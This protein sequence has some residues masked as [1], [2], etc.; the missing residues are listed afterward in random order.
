MT[1]KSDQ[2]LA[3]LE[4][5]AALDHLSTLKPADLSKQHL[6]RLEDEL[7]IEALSNVGTTMQFAKI[8]PDDPE[9]PEAWK[10]LDKTTLDEKMR[11]AK[12]AWKG[13]GEVP[14][15]LKANLQVLEGIL[16]NRSRRTEERKTL[17]V[18]SIHLPQPTGSYPQLDISDDND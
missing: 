13:S 3:K 14:F 5:Q 16:K 7:L 8:D 2:A 18:Q 15:G 11:V 12:A 6:E 1:K 17:N 9:V 10:D 4:R